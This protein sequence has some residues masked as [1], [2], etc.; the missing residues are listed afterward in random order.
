MLPPLPALI[1]PEPATLKLV[2][3]LFA[4]WVFSKPRQ[5]VASIWKMTGWR[6]VADRSSP[7]KASDPVHRGHFSLTPERGHHPHSR[8][9]SH[10][11]SVK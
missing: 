3:D 8:V 7:L 9:A 1:S 6:A 5:G 11:E 4:D 10:A 2:A